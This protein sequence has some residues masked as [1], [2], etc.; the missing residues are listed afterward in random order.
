MGKRPSAP[1]ARSGK[2]LEDVMAWVRVHGTV[3]F[4]ATLR[5]PWGFTVPKLKNATFHFVASGECWLEGDAIQGAAKLG[6]DDLVILPHGDRHTIRDAPNSS[7]PHLG[8][9]LS[10]HPLKEGCALDYGGKGKATVLVCGGFAVE[11]GDANPLV[12]SLPSLLR[13]PAE[14]LSSLRWL[15]GALDW[16]ISE[17]HDRGPGSETVTDRLAEILFVECLR[18]Y[19]AE[20]NVAEGGWV[21]ALVDP[22]IGP[23]LALIHHEPEARW[24]VSA[25][26]QHVGISRSVVRVEIRA[27][28][29]RTPL[30]YVTR[31][32]LGKA[33]RMLHTSSTRIPEIA[34]SVGY[35]SAVAFH[36]AFKRFYQVGPGEF[37]RTAAPKRHRRLAS[38]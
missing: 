21:Q 31:C 36:K 23:A 2:V 32:R 1:D 16:I 13:L 10:T 38:Q 9:L 14:R 4:H 28:R 35:G 18:A 24:T 15:R 22:V 11:N 17:I 27:A 5:A 7:V 20:C 12:G 25:I 8:E 34:R 19:C 37:R 26:A 3:F 6:T 33:A 30:Q 29:R